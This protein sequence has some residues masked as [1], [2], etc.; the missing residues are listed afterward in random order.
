VWRKIDARSRNYFCCG[1]A[2]NITYSK[3]VSGA[4]DIQHAMRLSCILLSRVACLALP[5]FFRI[6]SQDAR[7]FR[8][9]VAE[10]K[11]CFDFLY[12]FV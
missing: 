6:I 11:M 8:I 7:F 1:K 5:H 12:K 3:C 4:L 2:I 10:H 9:V